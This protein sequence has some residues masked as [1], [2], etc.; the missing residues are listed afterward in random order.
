MALQRLGDAD[1]ERLWELADRWT[2]S[3]AHEPPDL[4]L[5]R[6]VAAGVAEPRLVRA[7]TDARRALSIMDRITA[8]L[9]S[10]PAD[11]RHGRED[12][13]V[14]RQTLGYAWSVAAA[15]APDHGF[16]ALEHWAALDDAYAHW[17]VRSN[18]RKARL[19][20]ASGGRARLL[21]VANEGTSRDDA[22]KGE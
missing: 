4:L 22:E 6:A 11:R 18:A 21:L 15:G 2:R 12:V 8:A 10:I 17:I 14:L 9:L 1:P 19:M 16:A 3:D 7:A 20:N 13:R 5:L